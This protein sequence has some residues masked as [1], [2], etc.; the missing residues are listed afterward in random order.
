MTRRRGARRDRRHDVAAMRKCNLLWAA[1]DAL[2]A[3]YMF[4]FRAPN[5]RDAAEH[6]AG[7]LEPPPPITGRQSSLFVGYG[8]DRLSQS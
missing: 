5:D 6:K 3:R 7:T 8:P 1:L 4:P 2:G